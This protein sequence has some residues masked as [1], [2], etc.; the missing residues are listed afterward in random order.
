MVQ[1]S[2]VV[3]QQG[4]G[5]RSEKDSSPFTNQFIR[6]GVYYDAIWNEFSGYT[7]STGNVLLKMYRL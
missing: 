6:P 7:N 1:N 3:T 4:G 5:L 2:E